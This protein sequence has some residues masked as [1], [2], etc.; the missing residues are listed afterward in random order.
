MIIRVPVHVWEA[1]RSDDSDL[2]DA[3]RESAARAQDLASL[4]AMYHDRGEDEAWDGGFDE[5]ETRIDRDR[6]IGSLLD[7]LDERSLDIVQRRFGLCDDLDGPMTLDEIGDLWGVT[8]ERIRQLEKKIL[9]SLRAKANGEA[10]API[11]SKRVRRKKRGGE[12]LD[13]SAG[14]VAVRDALPS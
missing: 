4:E 13:A 14:T 3:L 6:T 8:R 2:T 11:S 9:D 10:T 5:L 1:L 12:G 7:G